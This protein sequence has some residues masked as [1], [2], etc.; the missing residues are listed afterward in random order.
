MV[1]WFSIDWRAAAI[2][3]KWKEWLNVLTR[4]VFNRFLDQ[5]GNSLNCPFK[6]HLQHHI[7]CNTRTGTIK[8][9]QIDLA[10]ARKRR[11]IEISSFS[12]SS[13][14]TRSQLRGLPWRPSPTKHIK[15]SKSHTDQL[16]VCKVSRSIT[17]I[18]YLNVRPPN[19][20]LM[21]GVGRTNWALI[22][23]NKCAK[24]IKQTAQQRL[25]QGSFWAKVA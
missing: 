14:S 24:P 18:G 19:D 9:D 17:R 16:P 2:W 12:Q 7:R 10:R 8:G 22:P 6:P 25:I 21:M 13:T 1:S 4:N 15:R 5:L 11:A 3:D 20:H 23:K